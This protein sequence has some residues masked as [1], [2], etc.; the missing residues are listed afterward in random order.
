[1]DAGHDRN[2]GGV[3]GRGGAVGIGEVDGPG[4][5]AFEVRRLDARVM[6]ERRD[7]VVQVVDGHEENVGL[8]RP[9]EGAGRRHH[10]GQEKGGESAHR[11][12]IG[13]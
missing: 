13:R 1:M 8:P 9:E 6:V 12:G 3:A 4:R 2:P 7:V 10:E 5:E 11:V